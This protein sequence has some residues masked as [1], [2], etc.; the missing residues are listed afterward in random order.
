MKVKRKSVKI[1]C[2]LLCLLVMITLPPRASRADEI[3]DLKEQLKAQQKT[4]SELQNRI[5][6][7]EAKQEQ[8]SEQVQKKE[9]PSLPDSLKWA[10][11]VKLSGDLR[12][13][14]ESIDSQK[15][16]AN[17]PGI[18][19]NRIRARLNLDAKLSD[20]WNVG[21]RLATGSDSYPSSTNQNLDNGFTK[22]NIWLD[23]A[24]FNW[25]PK[26]F[27]RLNVYGGRM[28]L[29]FYR[30]GNNQVIWDDDVNPE[31]IAAKYVIP[32][33]K[34]DSLYINGG[35]FWLKADTGSGT[36]G[37]SG[38]W[39]IQ[40]YFKHEF[41]NKDYL[42]A[43]VSLYA[44]HVKG[45]RQFFSATNDYG[46]TYQTIGGNN[47]YSMNYNVLEGFGEYCLMVAE[48]PVTV[49]GNYTKNTAAADS[50]DSGWLAG[51]TFN[52]AK[53]PGSWELGYNYRDVEKDTVVGLLT[54]SDFI[55]GGTNGRGHTLVGK[56]QMTR[57]I[58]AAITYLLSERLT[59]SSSYEKGDN[60]HRLM[61][62][63]IFKF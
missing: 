13:R 5:T 42:L 23:L 41:K 60:Y 58:Q 33:A 20:E 26:A 54:D 21:F 8:R 14:Y 45:K 10:E 63:L 11:N 55:G 7:L 40:S 6:Q 47:Y 3:G 46:N 27:D 59:D 44:A 57:N 16:G 32:L 48:F 30:V 19:N 52:K 22:K 35:G 36:D 12:Y 9:T 31:G 2:V 61:A 29:P 62:D 38:L 25:H 50:Q 51:V 43:G 17:Q 4:L 39:S 24:Y 18:N 37:G 1:L 34:T 56:Y 53:E 49:Y 28:P 15:K